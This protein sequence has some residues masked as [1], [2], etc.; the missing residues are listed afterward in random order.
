[1]QTDRYGLDSAIRRPKLLNL[2]LLTKTKVSFKK[3][4]ENEHE[5]HKRAKTVMS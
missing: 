5:K 1:M 2:D 4:L 3:Y